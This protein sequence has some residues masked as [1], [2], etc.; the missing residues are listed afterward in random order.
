MTIKSVKENKQQSKDNL[1]SYRDVSYPT[2]K[3]SMKKIN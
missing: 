3:A 2:E 1:F